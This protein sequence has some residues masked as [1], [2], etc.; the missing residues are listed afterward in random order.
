[1]NKMTDF[2]K[3]LASSK[4]H[5]QFHATLVEGKIRLRDKN[6]VTGI[7][8]PI[9][10]I[11]HVEQNRRFNMSSASYVGTLLGLSQLQVKRI[12]VSADCTTHKHKD[13]GLSTVVYFSKHVRNR[14]LKALGLSRKAARSV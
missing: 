6:N 4:L 5:E 1:M 3:C 9:T 12:I 10:A 14:M 11:L 8:C 2:Y 13:L 7:C